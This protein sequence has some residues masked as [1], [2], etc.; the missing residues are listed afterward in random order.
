MS[1]DCVVIG[2]GAAGLMATINAKR[3]GLNVALIE[4][5]DKLANKIL[6]T[7]NGKCNFS[8]TF[9]E[10]ECFQNEDKAK[11]ISVIERFNVSDLLEFFEELGVLHKEKNGYLYPR[12][13]SAASVADALIREVKRLGIEVILNSR[14]KNINKTDRG[15]VLSLESESIV[16]LNAD[17]LIIACG[18]MAAPKTGSDGSGYKLAGMLGNTVVKPLPALTALICDS[19]NMKASSGVRA[20]GKVSVF[21]DGIE[22]STEFGEIQ[23]T[24]YG[25]SGIPVFQISRYAVKALDLSKNVNVKINFFPEFSKEELSEIVKKNIAKGDKTTISDALS[26]IINKK[27]VNM[28]CRETGFDANLFCYKITEDNLNKLIDYLHEFTYNV[29]SYKGFEFAQVCQGGVSLSEID[30]DMQSNVCEGIF[31]AGEILDV[32]GKCG[33]YNLQW[34]FSSAFV[35]AL[36]VYRRIYGKEMLKD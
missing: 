12:S 10:K 19:K 27:L 25:I 33:G 7:G 21:V 22:E 2:G 23:F 13:E 18:S 31:Y 20:S 29:V 16:K 3:K 1:F 17:N 36:G 35:A 8:N 4:H 6:S 34:A 9:M 26:G 14:V 32:D 24:D 11:V 15:F 5:T 28:L 30:E